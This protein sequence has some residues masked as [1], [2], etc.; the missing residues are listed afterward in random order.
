MEKL[1]NL[2]FL[3]YSFRFKLKR[4]E[5]SVMAF[6]FK[7]K[8]DNELINSNDIKNLIEQSNSKNNLPKKN[9]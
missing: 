5:N 2:N 4:K 1:F 9:P 6:P 7:T 8:L 3:P